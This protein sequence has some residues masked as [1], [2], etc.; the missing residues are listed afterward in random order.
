MIPK[1]SEPSR[2]HATREHAVPPALLGTAANQA[3][4]AKLQTGSLTSSKPKLASSRCRLTRQDE[5][6]NQPIQ[7]EPSNGKAG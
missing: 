4:Q 3:N 2:R 7:G 6:D 1:S 5:C